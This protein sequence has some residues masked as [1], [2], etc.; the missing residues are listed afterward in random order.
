MKIINLVLLIDFFLIILTVSCKNCIKDSGNTVDIKRDLQPYKKL[1]IAGNFKVN[2][3][4]DSIQY[5][6]IH[7]DADV[8]S[9]IET[10]IN[11]GELEIINSQNCIKSLQQIVISLHTPAVEEIV[12][13]GSGSVKTQTQL[14]GKLLTLKVHGSG[15]INA[16]FYGEN[17]NCKIDGSGNISLAGKATNAS[18]LINGSGLLN[19][20][21]LVTKKTN[22]QVNGSGSI[23]TFVDEKLDASVSGSGSIIYSGNGY[24]NSKRAGS[25][26]VKKK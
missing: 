8:I 9:E 17:I 3:I 1:R 5:V 14:E 19:A 15:I 18:H 24:D 4:H 25:G 16:A 21:N 20:A 12:V 23:E 2:I 11:H 6:N 13:E 10:N 7:G 26:T 22:A